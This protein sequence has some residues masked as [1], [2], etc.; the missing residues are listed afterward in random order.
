MKVVTPGLLFLA[1][2]LLGS[3]VHAQDI[4]L[5]GYKLTFDDEFNSLSVTTAS[6]KGPATWYFAPPYGSAGNY[7]DSAWNASAFSLSGGIL[8]DLA[9]WSAPANQ[10]QSGNLS[11]IDPTGAGF[12][13]Q[14]GY[15]EARVEMPNAGTGAWPAFWLDSVSGLTG[16]QNEEVDIFEYY[17]VCNTPGSYQDFVQQASHNWTNGTDE[18]GL[19]SPQT[20]IPGGGYPWEGYHIYGCQ[21][22]PVHIT[23]YIDGVQTNQIATPAAYVTTPFYVMVD[24]AL[25]G[26]WSLTGN[27]FPQEG[28]SS[29]L[30]DWVRVYQLPPNVSTLTTDDTPT[31]PEWGLF[32]LALLL[33]LAAVSRGTSFGFPCTARRA[34]ANPTAG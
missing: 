1:G 26:G 14:Y 17:G 33:P 34:R 18:G 23:W 27:P 9:F 31:L 28:S 21:I 4:D 12:S 8:T 20:P 16:G 25:G 10:W 29:L 6:P 32:A 15:F 22:D 3:L 5:T 11:S 24:Y 13:Q 30:V 7:S 19:L 2:C